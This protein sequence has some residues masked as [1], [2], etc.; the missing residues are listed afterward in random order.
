MN[1][2]NQADP[3]V[4]GRAAAP[5]MYTG[6]GP[7]MTA[8]DKAVDTLKR[9]IY[10]GV[11]LFFLMRM[12]VFRATLESPHVSHEWFKVGLAGTIGTLNILI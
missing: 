12:N 10:I 8:G 1:R 7:Q 6:P 11:S 4:A 3:E 5:P 2:R 9:I